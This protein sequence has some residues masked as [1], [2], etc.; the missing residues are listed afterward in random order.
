MSPKARDYLLA[1]LQEPTT[2]RGIATLLTAFGVA[3]SPEQ[4]EAIIP[5]GMAV[6]GFIGILTKG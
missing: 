3:L 4:A 5:L 6:A 2:W 1:R